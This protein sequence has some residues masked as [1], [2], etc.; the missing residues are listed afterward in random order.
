M[1]AENW[2]QLISKGL[3]TRPISRRDFALN[4]SFQK[5][6]IICLFSK[7]AGLMQNRTLLSKLF[8][9]SPVWPVIKQT[10]KS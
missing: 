1:A 5:I 4:N 7:L 2:S 10:K 9:F 3:Y 8:T 6:E